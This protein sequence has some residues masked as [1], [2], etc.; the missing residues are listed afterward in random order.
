MMERVESI[1]WCLIVLREQILRGEAHRRHGVPPS[2]SGVLAGLY[3][4]L[5]KR[6]WSPP[7]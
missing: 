3:P 6:G 2:E 7:F 1:L 4:M 5:G